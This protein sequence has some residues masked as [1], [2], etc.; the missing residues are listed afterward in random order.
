MIGNE[1]ETENS[2]TRPMSRYPIPR[3][4]TEILGMNRKIPR[5]LARYTR[6]Y[7]TPPRISVLERRGVKCME[8]GFTKG[9]K[10]CKTLKLK[11]KS[12]FG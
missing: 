6:K 9:I 7:L 8:L 3:I 4:Y 12:T 1:R 5:P 10:V 2:I 11:K